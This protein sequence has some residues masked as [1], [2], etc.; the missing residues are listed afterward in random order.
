MSLLDQLSS[1][2]GA[3]VLAA[4]AGVLTKIARLTLPPGTYLL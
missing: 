2:I 4:A 3:A 1:Q